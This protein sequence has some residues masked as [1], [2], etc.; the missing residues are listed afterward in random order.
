[1]MPLRPIIVDKDLNVL[2]GNQRLLAIKKLGLKEIPDDWV[3][4]ADDLNDEEKRRFIIEDNVSF[5]DWDLDLINESYNLDELEDWGLDLDGFGDAPGEGDK[6]DP[7][8]DKGINSKD[9]FGVIVLC[10]GETDQKQ[11]F[12]RLTGEGFNCKIVVV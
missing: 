6:K 12:D 3:K 11:I 5:G 9:Q 8:D 10:A 2:G 7:F 1:M 4:I